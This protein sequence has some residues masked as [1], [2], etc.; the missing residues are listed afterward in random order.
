M[1][2]LAAPRH[3]RIDPPWFIEGPIDGMS[4]RTYVETVL[5]P[6]LRPEVTFGPARETSEGIL[7]STFEPDGTR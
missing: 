3:D 7:Y 1:T 4:F 2:L 6:P 5:L